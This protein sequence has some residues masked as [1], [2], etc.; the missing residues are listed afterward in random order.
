MATKSCVFLA[1]VLPG[2]ILASVPFAADAAA[3]PK[4]YEGKGLVA[5]YLRCEYLVDPLGLG[6]TAP[7]LSWIVESGERGQQQTAYRIMVA[8]SKA[9]LDYERGDLWDSGKVGSSETIGA[10]YQGRPLTSF[11]HCFWKVKVWDQAGRESPWTEP[12]MWA[13]GLL[14]TEDWRAQWIGY[15]KARQRPSTDAPLEGAKW[16]WHAADEIGKVPKCRRLFYAT[17]TLPPGT[18]VKHAELCASADDGMQLALNGHLRLTTE[19]RTT[20]GGRRE[21]PT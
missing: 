5:S 6:E 8:S 12:A 4:P 9:L 15:D 10:P 13:M 3:A 17:F 21:K 19:A 18:K 20:V 7:R 14:K 1:V 16:I 2:I 11:Q